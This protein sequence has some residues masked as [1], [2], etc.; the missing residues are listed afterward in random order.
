MVGVDASADQQQQPQPSAVSD[1]QAELARRVGAPEPAEQR[2]PDP[3]V[4]AA[5]YAAVCARP[6]N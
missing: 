6:A 5:S 4:A 3:A 1:F 2:K